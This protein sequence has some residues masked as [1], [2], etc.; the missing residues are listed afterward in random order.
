METLYDDRTMI[1]MDSGLPGPRS[2]VLGGVHGNERTGVDLVRS[3]LAGAYRPDIRRGSCIAALA[4]L[5]AIESNARFITHN[6]NRSLAR[7]WPACTCAE[8]V[9]SKVV[10][11]LL[12]QAD[13]LLDVH[14]SYNP[15]S[16][17]FVICERNALPI[18]RGLP[19]DTV[20]F[21]F[22][23]V[24]PGGTDEYMNRNGKTGICIECG[25]L[26]NGNG[27]LARAVAD[28]FFGVMNGFAPR[29]VA[30]QSFFQARFQYRVRSSFALAIPL[31]DF[32]VVERGQLLGKDGG[33]DVRAPT[34]GAVLFA[35][36]EPSPG[37]EAFVFLEP[38]VA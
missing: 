21:G 2:V 19:I 13:V 22:D 20:C 8:C 37:G 28:A 12:D 25:Y 27:N 1:R 16:R 26:G 31:A 15:Q 29:M 10:R 38:V 3:I 24:Q 23:A 6:M 18:V 5:P 7:D 34:A 17:P 4:N 9:R 36:D 35:S 32:E 30:S 11:D 14:E 33:E